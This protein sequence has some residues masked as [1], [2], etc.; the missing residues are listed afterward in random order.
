MAAAWLRVPGCLSAAGSQT[1]G[2]IVPL[3]T[4]TRFFHS[5]HRALREVPT[6][7]Q[8][9]EQIYEEEEDKPRKKAWH[10]MK[11]VAIAWAI[12]FP[13]GIVLFLFTKQQVQKDRLKQ[14]KIRQK[15]RAS[16]EGEYAR[17]RY[18]LATLR[19]EEVTETKT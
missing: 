14:L 10:P 12:G 16:N 7:S 5:S 11:K 4:P 15:L 17:E 2:L 19:T 13:S 1:A 3:R 8:P 9:G 6:K 18:K